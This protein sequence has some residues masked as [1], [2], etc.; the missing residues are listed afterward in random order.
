MTKPFVGLKIPIWKPCKASSGCFPKANYILG[1]P[2]YHPKYHQIRHLGD[3]VS[4][5]EQNPT[6]SL[7]VQFDQVFM[8]KTTEISC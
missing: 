1:H 5:C 7:G 2:V 6:M 3:I 4:S 8:E